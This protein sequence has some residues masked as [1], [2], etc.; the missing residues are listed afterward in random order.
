ML[1][2]IVFCSIVAGWFCADVRADKITLKDGTVYYGTLVEMGRKYRIVL[3][4]GGFKMVDKTEIARVETGDFSAEQG[5]AADDEEEPLYGLPEEATA[6]QATPRSGDTSST[7]AQAAVAREEIPT[8]LEAIRTEQGQALEDAIARLGE[9]GRHGIPS[10]KNALLI[11]NDQRRVA[12][13]RAVCRIGTPEAFQIAIDLLLND[14]AKE[15]RQATAASLASWGTRLTDAALLVALKSESEAATRTFIVKSQGR[16]DN[17]FAAPFLY[18]TAIT[19]AIPGVRTAAFNALAALEHPIVMAYA[20][21]MANSEVAEV[22]ARGA[23]LVQTISDPACIREILNMSAFG[24]AGVRT[25]ANTALQNMIRYNPVLTYVMMIRF[26]PREE[27]AGGAWQKLLTEKLVNVNFLLNKEAWYNWWLKNAKTQVFLRFTEETPQRAVEQAGLTM[28]KNLDYEYALSTTLLDERRYRKPDGAYDAD[29]MLSD[30]RY[31]MRRSMDVCRIVAVVDGEVSGE[32]FEPIAAPGPIG[33]SFILSLSAIRPG[34]I[35]QEQ[36]A[37]RLD[38]LSLHALA[39]SFYLDRCLDN[40][41]TCPARAFSTL[42]EL[43]A[44]EVKFSPTCQKAL[45][46]IVQVERLVATGAMDVVME[47]AS[48]LAAFEKTAFLEQLGYLGERGQCFREAILVWQTVMG[49]QRDAIIREVIKERISILQKMASRQEERTRN[50][51]ER[52][53]QMTGAGS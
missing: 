1:V 16:R 10:I 36:L 43:D 42:D 8:L 31:D 23:H 14:R 34:A 51:K 50:W 49:G 3:D 27:N 37:A 7:G 12:L 47:K 45:E 39:R 5:R 41:T 11:F 30:F 25:A 48:N 15:V 35:S 21:D 18:M 53:K 19:D 20:V 4:S 33:G 40:S 24:G 6:S 44:T 17:A 26:E 22:S 28:K 9:I 29:R 52:E 13:A 2:R 38:K 46:S 32:Q